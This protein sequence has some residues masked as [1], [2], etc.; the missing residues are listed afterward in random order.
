MRARRKKILKERKRARQQA[1]EE[2]EVEV[3]IDS[4]LDTN[5][6]EG[7]TSLTRQ[8]RAFLE[9]ASRRKQ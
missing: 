5:S 2:Q 7:L 1:R 6:Q 9:K 8:E 3:Q 4:L